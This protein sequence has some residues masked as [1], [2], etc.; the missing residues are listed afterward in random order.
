[1]TFY[2]N[3]NIYNRKIWKRWKSEVWLI[4]IAGKTYKH[5]DANA[6]LSSSIHH[7]INDPDL[8]L[9]ALTHSDPT[10]WIKAVI[11][12]DIVFEVFFGSLRYFDFF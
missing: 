10:T 12:C 8:I 1:M 6:P 2:I 3:Y 9:L 5:G 7:V 4:Y 11:C